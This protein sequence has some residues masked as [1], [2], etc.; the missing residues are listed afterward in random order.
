MLTQSSPQPAYGLSHIQPIQLHPAAAS[1]P[2]VRFWQVERSSKMVAEVLWPLS[3]RVMEAGAPCGTRHR[4]GVGPA[5]WMCHAG[6]WRGKS[7]Q[8]CGGKPNE[9][10]SS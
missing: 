7:A 10:A 9:V 1:P 5:G 6:T 4:A 8:W 2:A 3:E